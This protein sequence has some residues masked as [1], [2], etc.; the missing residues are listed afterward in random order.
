[1]AGQTEIILA[2]S[3][4]EQASGANSFESQS[5]YFR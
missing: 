1:M 4:G 2:R 5:L 3:G